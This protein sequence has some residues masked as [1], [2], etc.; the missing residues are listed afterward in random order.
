MPKD[1][2]TEQPAQKLKASIT[3]QL[4]SEAETDI[5]NELTALNNLSVGNNANTR[6]G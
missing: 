6:S 5:D 3:P 1:A 4:I 2:K